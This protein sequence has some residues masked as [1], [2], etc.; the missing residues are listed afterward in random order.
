MTMTLPQLF[1]YYASDLK[2]VEAKLQE[3]ASDN[4]HLQ[5]VLSAGGHR[6]RPLLALMTFH[7]VARNKSDTWRELHQS[8][9]YALAAALELL[10]TASLVHDDVI[11]ESDS[12]RQQPTLN[13]K[14]S[15]TLAVL[16]GNLFYLNAFKYMI[17]LN[18]PIWL[19]DII[20]TA[21]AMCYGEI[22]QL[23]TQ[24][25]RL[26]PATYLDIIEKKTGRL[27][28]VSAKLGA[29]LGEGTPAEIDALTRMAGLMG[30]LYQLKDDLQDGDISN[31][32]SSAFMTL[33]KEK[34]QALEAIVSEMDMT[35]EPGQAL[36]AIIQYFK[37]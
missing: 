8:K 12:R 28:E 36:L 30:L 13:V 18:N 33:K 23:E 15:N 2:G 14:T 17:E 3:A 25:E 1:E 22:I 5:Y 26:T 6:W 34:T 7:Y 35:S 10:H 16:A 32:E 19:S 4:P 11:D 20:S 9:L 21:E 31:L 29:S 27:I 37:E 24:S